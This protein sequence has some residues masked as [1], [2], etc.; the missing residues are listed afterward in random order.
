MLAHIAETEGTSDFQDKKP[1]AKLKHT[2]VTEF[3]AE[4]GKKSREAICKIL[5]FQ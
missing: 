1:K 4:P 3:L 5:T 2:S